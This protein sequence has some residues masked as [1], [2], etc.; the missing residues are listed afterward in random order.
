MKP[1]AAIA[2]GAL[3]V[4]AAF[5]LDM[6]IGH[7]LAFRN[8]QPDMSLAALTP[9]AL[10]VRAS[11]GAWLGLFAGVLKGSFVS[12]AFG[13]YAVSRCLAGWLTG[14]LQERFFRDNLFVTVAAG[15]MAS[16]EA[17][18]TFFAFAPQPDAAQYWL[19]SGATALYTAVWVIPFALL[20]RRMYPPTV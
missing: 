9:V 11:G 7:R 19:S 15:F 12:L 16:L 4:L 3:L 13:S 5:V 1:A 17:D 8:V 10:A 18:L 2:R 14:L 6:A 20:V